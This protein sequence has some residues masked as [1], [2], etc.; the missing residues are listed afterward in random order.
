MRVDPSSF[1]VLN[2][3]NKPH[4]TMGKFLNFTN[5]YKEVFKQSIFNLLTISITVDQIRSDQIRT[6]Q[7]NIRII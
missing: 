3:R 4:D 7:W 6:N 2:Y 1:V 5:Q